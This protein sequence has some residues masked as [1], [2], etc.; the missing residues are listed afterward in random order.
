MATKVILMDTKRIK[1]KFLELSVKFLT[2]STSA[3]TAELI[4][5]LLSETKINTKNDD[6]KIKRLEKIHDELVDTLD[7]VNELSSEAKAHKKHID[8]LNL[9]IKNLEEDKKSTET[10]LQQPEESISR[11][12]NKANSKNRI[13]GIVEGFCLG[14]LGSIVA[15]FIYSWIAD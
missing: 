11:I 4:T 8:E 12:I 2:T 13:R 10:I 9:E 15:S 3:L 5:V 6:N 14:I 7:Y 1:K